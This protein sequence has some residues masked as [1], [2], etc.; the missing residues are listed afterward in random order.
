[1]DVPL[2]DLR[3]WI[4]LAVVASALAATA[5]ILITRQGENPAARRRAFDIRTE[6]EVSTLLAGIP[7]EGNT[8][9][10]PTAPV[11]LQMF[12]DLECLTAKRWVLHL[13]PAIIQRF[14]RPGI[15]KIQYRSLKTDTHNA[16]VFINQQSAAIAAGKQDKMWTFAETFYHEQGREYTPYVTERYLDGIASQVPSLNLTQWHSERAPGTFSTQVVSDDQAAR[17]FGMH[18]TP[19]FAIGHTGSK[20]KDFVGRIIFLEFPG[21]G[22]MKYPVSLITTQDLKNAIKELT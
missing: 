5:G 6:R 1:V 16:T 15:I 8:L 13:L 11:T 19:G 17:S 21:F 20:L 14:V 12:S 7:Q 4:V 18:D 2:R 22:M 10:R 3:L 9:G